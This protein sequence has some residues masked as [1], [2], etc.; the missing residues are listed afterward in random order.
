M[1]G[2]KKYTPACKNE[3]VGL[4]FQPHPSVSFFVRAGGKSRMYMGQN[5][6]SAEKKIAEGDLWKN[7]YQRLKKEI[8][9]QFFNV[10]FRDVYPVVW[11]AH[12]L[13]IESADVKVISH[14]GNRYATLIKKIA[15]E[16]SGRNIDV[17]LRVAQPGAKGDI[18]NHG[19]DTERL[20]PGLPPESKQG[21]GQMS[22]FDA[23]RDETA[24]VSQNE[25]Q[26]YGVREPKRDDFEKLYVNPAYTFDRFVKGPS[27]EHALAAALGAAQNPMKYHNP[28]YL[29]GGVGLG[30][31]H[32]LMAMANYVQ[33]NFPW[34]K[35]RYV[36]SEVF[37]SDL[38]EAFARKTLPAF[39]AKYR[40]VDVL[41]IDDIQFVSARAEYTQ[42][43]IFHIF[44]YLYQNNK[45]I[46][47]S[48]DRPPQQL[49]KLK[50]RLVSRFQSGLI[51][52][53]KPPE[54][55]TR[56]AIIR[57]RALEMNLE[58][59]DESVRWIAANIRDQVRLLEASLIRLKFATEYEE[60]D[61]GLA[62]TQRVL[63][64][65]KGG[66][67]E[68][69]IDPGQ[70]MEAVS[71][72]FHVAED[73]ILSKSRMERIALA[74]HVAMYLM[75]QMIPSY[76]LLKIAGIFSRN[77]HT[78]VLNAQKKV[79]RMLEQDSAFRAKVEELSEQIRTAAD[80][81]GFDATS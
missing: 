19:S 73:E 57:K 42:E 69:K 75:R 17:K 7:F 46:V 55:E 47:I 62:L 37:Q 27:N 31:T 30:K 26:S 24:V 32:L 6:A 16:M 40:D 28:L 8:P 34:L 11:D 15:R 12:Q 1:I 23:Y 10:F 44:N 5:E 51:V 70:I 36:S 60:S 25:T 13:I 48:G 4:S 68:Q 61:P 52:D 63:S 53:I 20:R 9:G 77:D 78:T 67:K 56:E 72:E 18:R 45:Q 21:N 59:P 33:N 64:D 49:S 58:L 66:V 22:I 80:E 35:C 39:K 3:L 81:K 14:I 54:I 50:D 38:V 79:D 71:R 43:T 74:R 41:L 29:Y 2:G 76:S 65:I